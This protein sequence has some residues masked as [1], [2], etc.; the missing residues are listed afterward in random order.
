VFDSNDQTRW[1]K[2]LLIAA[3]LYVATGLC[4]NIM[5]ANM[6]ESSPMLIGLTGSILLLFWM[7]VFVGA[8]CVGLDKNLSSFEVWGFVI[9]RRLWISVVLVLISAVIMIP[10]LSGGIWSYEPSVLIKACGATLEEVVFRG[11]LIN[12]L[13]TLIQPKSRW[14]LAGIICVCAMIFA[15]V[16]IPTHP[17][18]EVWGA[19]TSAIALG[20]IYYFT[21]SLLLPIFGHAVA[22]AGMIGGVLA[23]IGYFVIAGSV[24]LIARSKVTAQVPAT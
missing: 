14:G 19:F 2:L 3:G 23:I 6:S 8:G 13:L 21:R 9:N 1:N 18:T 15:A 20:Y 10:Q 17:A 16:H 22:N 7:T 5:R 4:H 12:A 11:I 24:R